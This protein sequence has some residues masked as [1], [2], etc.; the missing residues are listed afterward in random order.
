MIT[1]ALIAAAAAHATPPPAGTVIGNRAAATYVNASGDSVTVTSN[2]VETIVQQIGAVSLVTSTAET[3]APG[4]KVFLPHTVTNDGNGVDAFDLIATETLVGGGG[5][6]FTSIVIYPDA[7]MDGVADGTTPIAATPTLAA[8]GSFGIIIEASVPGGASASASESIDIVATSAFDDTAF[9]T[10]TDTITVSTGAVTEI[11]K[12]MTVTD[13][14]GAAADGVTGPGDIVT[15]TLTYSSTGLVGAT[16]L[17]VTD[18]LDGAL[19]YEAGSATWSDVTGA[20]TDG[21]DG[22]EAPNGGGQRIDFQYD[23]TDTVAFQIDSVPSGRTGSVTFSAVIADGTL[24]GDIENTATQ[25]VA[26]A[27]QPS[28]NTATVTLDTHYAVTAAD[29][30]SATHMTGADSAVN[31]IA[32]PASTTDTDGVLDDTVTEA[33]D[34][35]Q[36]GQIA[37]E[38]VLTNHSNVDDTIAVSVANGSFPLGTTFQLLQ[39]DGATPVVGALG[40]LANGESTPVTVIATL[41]P[42]AAPVAA[43][44]TNY[45]A[46]LSAQSAN[47]GAVNTATALFTGAVQAASV[48]LENDDTTGDGPNPTDPGGNPWK[49]VVTDPGTPAPM[50]VTVQNGGATADSYALSLETP[51]PTGWTVAFFLPDGTPVSNTGAIPAGGEVD[52]TVVVTPPADSAPVTQPVTLAVISPSSGQGDTLTNA[53]SINEI[54]D[55]SIV[56][57]QSAQVSAGGVQD[58]VHTLKNDGNIALT[59]GAI[60]LSGTFSTFAGALFLDINGDGT[61]DAND[62]S[63]DNINDIAGGIAPGGAAQIILRVQAPS[64]GAIGVSETETI[65]VAATLNG[66]AAIEPVAGRGD[67]AVTDTVTIVSNDLTLQ[68]EQAL[69]AACNGTLGAYTTARIN[70]EPGQCV[71]YRITASNTGTD[72]AGSVTI[73][74]TMPGFT[75]FTECGGNCTMTL[76][77]AGSSATA[78]PAEGGTG[79]LAT[80]HGTLAP[81]QPATL[82]FTVRIDQ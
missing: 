54:V 4:G 70:A 26:G 50:T 80:S 13:G 42:D 81:G 36:G 28:S 24:A 33:A 71:R 9:A 45:T 56:P 53:V 66:G 30:A 72:N 31:L 76:T 35:F 65:T 6:D 77:P 15:V 78:T 49:T 18:I 69:D 68:K 52:I 29:A 14:T 44:S 23:G 11:V 3:V 47:G 2:E 58:L 64:T 12:R 39:S 74:D 51:L 57:P 59:E 61:V 82:S 79:A 73:R 16:D 32:S 34:V 1:T 43:G 62:I 46:T 55:V 17:I 7:N 67:N 38:F 48:D 21:D 20:L 37:F 63:I 40:P 75:T 19:V 10:N 60:T 25:T 27:P 5:F 8:G 41:S 22:Y